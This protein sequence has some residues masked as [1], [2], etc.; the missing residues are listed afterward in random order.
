MTDKIRDPPCIFKIAFIHWESFDVD[1]CPFDFRFLSLLS[2]I[3]ILA[4]SE[5]WCY[6][7]PVNY[8]QVYDM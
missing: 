8:C 7:L 2:E 1:I 6:G 3:N 4:K 5:V